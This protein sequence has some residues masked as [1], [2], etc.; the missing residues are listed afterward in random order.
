MFGLYP[1]R[2]VKLCVCEGDQSRFSKMVQVGGGNGKS[3]DDAG[4]VFFL[5]LLLRN[6]KE[7]SRPLQE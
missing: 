1:F 6:G 7:S 2:A 5:P 4:A 3:I